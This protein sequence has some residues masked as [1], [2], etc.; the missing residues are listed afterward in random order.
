MK[1][2]GADG[3]DIDTRAVYTATDGHIEYSSTVNNI[4][5]D[6]I[7]YPERSALEPGSK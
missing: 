4:H 7:G 5:K 2:K 3:V 1:H 6:D